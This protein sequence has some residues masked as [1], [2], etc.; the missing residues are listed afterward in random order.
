MFSTG[1]KAEEKKKLEAVEK[2]MNNLSFKVNFIFSKSTCAEKKWLV[3]KC[4]H[5]VKS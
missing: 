3:N 4:V 1:V 2:L 5:L